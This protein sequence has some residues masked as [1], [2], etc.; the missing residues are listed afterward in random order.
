[1]KDSYPYIIRY[2]SQ[3][4]IWCRRCGGL[5][6]SSRS[7]KKGIGQRCWRAERGLPPLSWK[8]SAI[9]E[10]PFVYSGDERYQQ[11]KIGDF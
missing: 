6:T 9:D 3:H 4:Y 2:L 1:M 11:M 8:K 5:L 7:R 10:V